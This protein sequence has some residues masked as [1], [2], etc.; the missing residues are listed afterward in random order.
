MVTK[1]NYYTY[2]K[3]HFPVLSHFER[4]LLQSFQEMLE[5]ATTNFLPK[6]SADIKKMQNFLLITFL[7]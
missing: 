6:F 2:F 3:R 1:F 7:W 4:A 5:R